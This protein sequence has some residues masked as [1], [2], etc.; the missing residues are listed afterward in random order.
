MRAGAIRTSEGRRLQSFLEG[1]YALVAYKERCYW[2]R[3]DRPVPDQWE[4]L[5]PYGPE[6]EDGRSFFLHKMPIKGS[7]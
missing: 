6:E 1:N 7:G 5:R 3:N 2:L 4:V